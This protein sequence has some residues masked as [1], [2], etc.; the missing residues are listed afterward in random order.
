MAPLTLTGSS[1]SSESSQLPIDFAS[2]AVRI[3]S[4]VMAD[5]FSSA[6]RAA[7]A[8]SSGTYTFNRAIH[9]SYTLTEMGSG[10]R[11]VSSRLDVARN[12]GAGSSVGGELDGVLALISMAQL[13][14]RNLDADLVQRLRQRAAANGRSAEEEHR[15]VLR[16]A[17]RPEGLFQSLLAIPNVGDD[18]DF[19]RQRELPRDVD[20]RC[21]AAT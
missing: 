16:H 8:S 9:T 2:S 18:A 3:A 10:R 13:I 20:V 17:L 21:R 15:H 4:W 5:T 12:D 6:A 1:E 11:R 19:E 7:S 14:V